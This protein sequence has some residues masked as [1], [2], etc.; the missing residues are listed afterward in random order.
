[1]PLTV[2]AIS[3]SMSAETVVNI[4]TGSYTQTDGIDHD[5]LWLAT[6]YIG[7][8]SDAPYAWWPNPHHHNSGSEAAA[9]ITSSLWSWVSASGCPMSSSA[10]MIDFIKD[11][12]VL[13]QWEWV[14]GSDTYDSNFD[15]LY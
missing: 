9:Q 4:L 6:N 5:L 7:G 2:G 8:S 3:E 11:H 13:A 1:M 15:V 10:Q 14:S 12:G